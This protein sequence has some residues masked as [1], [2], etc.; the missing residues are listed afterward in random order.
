MSTQSDLQPLRS[1][2][3]TVLVFLRRAP[4]QWQLFAFCVGMGLAWGLAHVLR[5]SMGRR[6]RVSIQQHA[7]AS[8]W[9]VL[10]S[11][12][13]IVAELA[14]PALA[15]LVM[16]VIRVLLEVRGWTVG[17]LRESVLLLWA[18]LLYRLLIA[19]LAF[20]GEERICPFRLRL[21]GPLFWLVVAGRVLDFAVNL[22]TLSGVQVFRLSGTLVTLGTLTTIG[23]VLYFLYTS[24]WIV[25]QV[26]HVLQGSSSRARMRSQA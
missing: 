13:P 23:V 15:L 3:L 10:R 6:L 25:Q 5:G 24:A 19:L 9:T 17:L 18:F 22:D 2:I 21:I 26:Q 7:A 20:L 11:C 12:V 14:L 1:A 16:H 8:R 4:V